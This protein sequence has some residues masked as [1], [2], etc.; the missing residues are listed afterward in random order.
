MQALFEGD[1]NQVGAKI[2]SAGESGFARFERDDRWPSGR[3]AA[4]GYDE[5]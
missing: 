2:R 3:F 1:L 5:N 4:E